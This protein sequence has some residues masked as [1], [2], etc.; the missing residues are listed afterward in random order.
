MFPVKGLSVSA[1]K[2]KVEPG[3]IVG[4]APAAPAPA[5][6][7][8]VSASKPSKKRKRH[9][10]DKDVNVDASNLVD[11]WEKVIE[12]KKE[13]VADG[14]KKHENKRL[15]KEHEGQGEKL[16]NS[17]NDGNQGERKK[18]K[19][20][21][22][23]KNKNQG[24]HGI[25]VAQKKG[26]KKVEGEEDEDDNN[27]DADEWEGID[28]DEKHASSEKPTPKKDDKKQQQLQQQQQQKK[29]QKNQEKDN[30]NGTTSNWQ[31]DKPQPKTATPAPKLTPLQASMREKL[32]SA[33]FRHLNETLYT[34][35]S[36]EAFK[37]FEESPEMFTE[38]HEGFRRQV[39]VWPE[40]PVDVYI[41]EIKE[42]AKVR[43]APKISGGAEGGKSLPPA[44][45]PLPRDQ[46]TKVCTI[47]DLGCGDAKLAK[48][49]VPLKQKLRL[50]IHSFD[51]QTGGCELV[52]RAD[53]ANLP[54][55]DNSVD[56]AIFCL[57]LMGTNW[58]DFVEEA[59][60][61]LR[62]RGELWVAE[63]KS[64]F[65]GSQARVKQP[66]QKK[67]VAHSVGK[68][69]KGS[70]LAVAEEEE[71]GDPEQNNLDLAVHVDGDTSK[72]KKP[73]ETD[74]TA[75]VEALKRRGFLLNRDFGDNSVDMG[76]KMFVRMHF[77]KAAVPTRG[78]CVPK[79]GQEDTIKNKKGGQKPKPKF[80][81]EKDEQEEVKNEAAVL[82]PCVYK[83][84]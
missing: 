61:I 44:R 76:N 29:Q 22:K 6:A 53:I 25:Q 36:T 63:I 70:A 14:V 3:A 65:A 60:R 38:Y 20:K 82:K 81:E 62:W 32:I 28:E 23:N 17:N 47:A 40:N 66:P 2:L 78:K 16:S 46:K 83:I 1:D 52:T 37:L 69:K 5:S 30:R 80:I 79:D 10:G 73:H 11:L 26:P 4:T 42:R 9:G 55:P 15:K 77:V 75:F 58:L 12:Q 34:R 19:K 33:R 84:R 72:L 27:D 13:G 71:E 49:L 51:L 48:T 8:A 57:A 21:N 56:L 67:V 18:N 41:K 50:E 24:E 35:P 45:F 64:R 59:Y 68:R 74:I 39:D 43:F 54:L 31:Q 7:P